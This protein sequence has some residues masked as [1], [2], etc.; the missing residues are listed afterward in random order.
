MLKL[1]NVFNLIF[2]KILKISL[3][4]LNFL[5]KFSFK[6]YKIMLIFIKVHFLSLSKYF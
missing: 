1:L 5:L 4:F 3:I 2:I 6:F